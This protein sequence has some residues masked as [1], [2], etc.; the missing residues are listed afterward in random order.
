MKW[1]KLQVVQQ[2]PRKNSFLLVICLDAIM[3]CHVERNDGCGGTQ[4]WE[5]N[6]AAPADGI[7]LNREE[8]DPETPPP[9]FLHLWHPSTCN[10]FSY[11]FDAI[12]SVEIN[13]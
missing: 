7:N 5:E 3:L 9:F 11:S 8:F 1:A 6:R 10:R 4:K 12:R 13:K 2:G